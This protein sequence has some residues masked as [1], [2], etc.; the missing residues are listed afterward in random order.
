MTLIYAGIDE[1]GYGPLL[2]P[3]CV[4]CAVLSVDDWR[5]GD[6]APDLWTLLGRAVCRSPKDAR[7]RIAIDDSKKLKLANSSATTHPLTHLE[8]G[9]LSFLSAMGE[10][11]RECTLPATDEA[12]FCAVAR[13][14]PE[15]AWYALEPAAWPV[16]T[17]ESA[18]RVSGSMLKGEM[19]RAGVRAL[20]LR[21]EII[22]EGAFNE[23]CTRGGTKAA[24][25]ESA[26]AGHLRTLWD[27][28]GHIGAQ[29]GGGVRVVCDR[30]GGRT[31]YE[32]L[33]ARAIPG[34][35][36]TITHETAQQ[37][38]YELRGRD[39]D[40]VERRMS[41][42]FLVESEQAHMP[43][44]LASMLAKLT[45]E[46]LMA[47]FNRYWCARLPELKPTAG[48][49]GDGWRWIQEAGPVLDENLRSALIRVV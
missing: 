49:R 45:R 37:S 17:T 48:Y 8:R 44:A 18:L 16:G 38:R 40:G 39:A 29:D 33:L 24:A 30:Q 46:S 42:L 41:V 4:G 28:H 22:G 25:T 31:R 2:G 43:V 36:V 34:C 12:F 9:V 7:R 27:A 26:L 19:A 5:E 1:A 6:T 23:L 15:E 20:D 47:R 13:C 32:D 3:L 14:L 11:E 35:N 21:C 10:A